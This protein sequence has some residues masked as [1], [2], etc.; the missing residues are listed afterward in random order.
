MNDID[1]RG[2]MV[3]GGHLSVPL[4][5]TIPAG[6]GLTVQLGVQVASACP[7]VDGGTVM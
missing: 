6:A 2:P 4:A 5:T 7:N 1:A 3:G